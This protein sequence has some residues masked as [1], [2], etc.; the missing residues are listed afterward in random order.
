MVESDNVVEAVGFA[1]LGLDARLSGALSYGVPTPIQRDAIP[2]LLEGKDLVG[3]AGT[4]TGKT[5]AFALPIIHR[6]AAER[7]DAAKAARS[8]AISCSDASRSTLT[9]SARASVTCPVRS[10]RNTT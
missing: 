6:L 5:A 1:S 3:L 4:G 8:R 10:I 2:I 7:A 9:C